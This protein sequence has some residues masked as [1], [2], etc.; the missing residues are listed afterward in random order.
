MTGY[1]AA[2]VLTVGVETPLYALALRRLLGER[3]R[4]R[5]LVAA[6]V[7]LS[8]HPLTW[9]VLYP[10]VSNLVAVEAFAV[11]WEAV[12]L[13]A[14]LRREPAVLAA[15]ALVVNGVSLGLGALL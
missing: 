6:A 12:W 3:R 1:L 2:L 15:T 4:S 11:A 14:W 5:Y 10:L 7:N 8:S 13:W 9:L